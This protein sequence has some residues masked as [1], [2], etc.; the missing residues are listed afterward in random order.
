MEEN[1][2]Y[3]ARIG[4]L[5]GR[6]NTVDVEYDTS[7]PTRPQAGCE[8]SEQSFAPIIEHN[9]SKKLVISIATANKLCNLQNCDHQSCKKNFRADSSIASSERKLLH[10]NLQRIRRSGKLK[11]RSVTSDA[12]AQIAKALRDYNSLHNESI[13]HYKCFVHK[14]RNLQKKMKAKPLR[15]CPKRF[16]K[17]VYL[18]KLSSCIRARVRLE[19][20][21]LRNVC[22]TDS[23]FIIKSK[24]AIGNIMKCFGGCHSKCRETSLVCISHLSSYSASFLPYGIHLELKSEDINRIQNEL[25]TCFGTTDLQSICK[26]YST[27]MCESVHAKVFS[28]APKSTSWARNFA[29]L[30]HSATHSLSLGSGRATIALAKAIG[31]QVKI[32]SPMYQQLIKNDKT[33]KYH[34]KRKKTKEYKHS[35]YLSKKRKSNRKQLECSLY[36]SEASSSQASSEH[37]YGHSC[38][39]R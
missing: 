23:Q 1:Q 29:G 22:C 8:A 15:T 39:R 33:R 4:K 37:N 31:L 18:Q 17:T 28:Y 10:D 35:R 26:I 14:L 32:Q 5:T 21:R 38:G 34:A 24:V 7:F 30:C 3:V 16:D 27:N 20:V 19:L 36:S 11:V 2:S 6:G 9:T 12:S 25:N 13:K